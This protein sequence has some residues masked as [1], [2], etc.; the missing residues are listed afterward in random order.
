MTHDN[1]AYNILLGA[2]EAPI[3]LSRQSTLR[4]QYEYSQVARLG[5]RRCLFCWE[6]EFYFVDRKPR[7][8]LGEQLLCGL[9][10]P[11]AALHAS[12]MMQ[13]S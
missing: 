6:G 9:T 11:L 1:G 10:V 5:D 8:C 4:R 12:L 3:I 2:T 7:C 13:E